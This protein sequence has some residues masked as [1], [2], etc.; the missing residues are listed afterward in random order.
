MEIMECS[1]TRLIGT[2]GEHGAPHSS[3][4]GVEGCTHELSRVSS[5]CDV[6]PG[7][8]G[9]MQ[10]SETTFLIYTLLGTQISV[11]LITNS[12]TAST[13]DCAPRSVAFRTERCKYYEPLSARTNRSWYSGT[14]KRM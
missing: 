5:V 2:F 8:T 12:V 1:E 14:S 6:F 7:I 3:V 10:F 9:E 11:T 13:R 4:E